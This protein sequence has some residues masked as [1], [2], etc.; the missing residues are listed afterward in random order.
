MTNPIYTFRFSIA[1]FRSDIGKNAIFRQRIYIYTD[2]V[3]AEICEEK[4]DITELDFTDMGDLNQWDDTKQYFFQIILNDGRK[5]VGYVEKSE[6]QELLTAKKAIKAAKKA[7]NANLKKANNSN[8]SN[9]VKSASKTYS[10][11]EHIQSLAALHTQGIL[12][13][14]DFEAAKKKVIG[15]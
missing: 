3:L 11:A 10:I 9:K 5:L 14:A 4:I 1:K 2:K 12:N 7:H 6:R 13:D 15:I 8:T